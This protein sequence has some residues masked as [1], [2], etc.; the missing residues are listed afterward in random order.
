MQLESK[1]LSDNLIW[2]YFGMQRKRKH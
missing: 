2:I 1:G